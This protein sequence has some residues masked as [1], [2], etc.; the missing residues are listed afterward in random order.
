MKNPHRKL[1]IAGACAVLALHAARPLPAAEAGPDLLTP[2][3]RMHAAMAADGA[4]GVVAAA[5]EIAAAA[6]AASK[7]GDHA[8]AYAAV[9]AAAKAM[10]GAD[11]VELRERYRTLSAAM[12][13]LVEAG[14]L[15]GADIYHCS[16][17]PGYWLQAKGDTAV[18]NPYYG[19]SMLACGSK[20][21]KVEG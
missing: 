14:A 18:R 20:V 2:Y 15:G 13:K 8:A 10:G 9:A 7:S 11:L 21:E 3:A 17:V 5:G 12:A 4:V 1:A 16:M 19:K 6:G